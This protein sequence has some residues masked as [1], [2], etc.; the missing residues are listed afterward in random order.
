MGLN[1]SAG[2]IVSA[3][4][5]SSVP[6][7]AQNQREERRSETRALFLAAQDERFVRLDADGDGVVSAAEMQTLADDSGAGGGARWGRGGGGFR[8]LS[9]ADTNG[10]GSI[11][12]A[13]HQ[14]NLSQRFDRLDE[15]GD[16]VI[17]PEERRASWNGRRS[18]SGK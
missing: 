11:T 15:D 2:I 5:F 17:T 4:L 13:E 12:K 7:M 14:A 1:L 6:A 16:G 18:G 3:L 10:D 9:R 8:G